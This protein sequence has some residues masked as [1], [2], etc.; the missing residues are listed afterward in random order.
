[1]PCLP[2]F[3]MRSQASGRPRAS[4]RA[5]DSDHAAEA[6]SPPRE[7][8]AAA[9]DRRAQG[10]FGAPHRAALF[11]ILGAHSTEQQD[12]VLGEIAAMARLT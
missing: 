2:C 7:T 4:A 5:Q 12:R 8:A 1:M 11:A 6:P 9:E 3:P 10:G